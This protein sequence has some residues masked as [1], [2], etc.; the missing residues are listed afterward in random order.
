MQPL[1][2][3]LLFLAMTS[4]TTVAQTTSEPEEQPD[5]STAHE[6]ATEVETEP[7][8]AFEMLQQA[9]YL[10][11][12]LPVEDHAYQL[13]KLVIASSKMKHPM[14]RQWVTEVF[15]LTAGLPQQSP[16]QSVEQGALGALAEVD[17]TEALRML[18]R[19]SPATLGKQVG[20]Q[21]FDN[22][23]N[24]AREVFPKYIQE[25]QDADLDAIRS[26]AIYL[27]ETGQYPFQAVG[28]ILKD[29]SAIDD[30]VAESLFLDAMQY[31]QREQINSFQFHIEFRQLLE[32]AKGVV[33]DA[34][35]RAA[36]E[37]A[38]HRLLEQA[39]EPVPETQLY[40]GR[41]YTGNSYIEPHSIA[42]D[43]IYRLLPLVRRFAPD[44]EV[45]IRESL[46]HLTSPVPSDIGPVP[47]VVSFTAIRFVDPS[48]TETR[49]K[50][51]T[52]VLNGGLER[53]A[54]RIAATDLEAAIRIANSITDPTLKSATLLAISP[55]KVQDNIEGDESKL[56]SSPGTSSLK[57]EEAD[58]SNQM[59]SL[60]TA[61]RVASNDDSSDRWS[62][63]KRALD[64]AE[65]L[66]QKA[67]V[68]GKVEVSYWQTED[69]EGPGY[70]APG[71][72]EANELIKIGMEKEK[73]NTLGWLAQ[74]HDPALKSYLL[75]S[76][77]EG[78]WSAEPSAASREVQTPVEEKSIGI[79]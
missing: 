31:Y 18:S 75:I 40:F 67:R 44:L 43:M 48:D 50:F 14:L 68:V 78:L 77:A 41:T 13:G 2:A 33:P 39:E 7:N 47:E 72:Q 51:E 25:V 42:E 71:F 59:A 9:Y 35:E 66:F 45:R 73:A 37:M 30:A 57:P 12:Q 36:L 27:G 6:V 5:Q 46:P 3:F 61:A 29:V 53:A 69:W 38:M 74:Q 16:R 26:A 70:I 1:L 4:S 58:E 65:E 60:M 62:T 11:G 34:M 22:R 24:A 76:A 56:E 55:D 17:P 20:G 54:R 79:R 52:Q 8:P 63:L 32:A 49:A 19:M 64:F 28:M 21:S 23:S 10:G 15:Q